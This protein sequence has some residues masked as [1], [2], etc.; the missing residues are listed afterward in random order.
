MFWNFENE[1]E[2]TEEA[3]NTEWND[4]MREKHREKQ[5]TIQTRQIDGSTRK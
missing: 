1:T 3:E 5:S 2:K 4:E